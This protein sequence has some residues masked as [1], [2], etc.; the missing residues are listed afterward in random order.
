MNELEIPQGMG[1][2]IRT[3]GSKRT[4][5]EI[6]RDFD[7]LLRLWENIRDLTMKSIAPCL[8][9]EEAS[10]IK[11]AIRDMYD[12][13]IGKVYVEGEV[14]YREAKDF[15]KMLMPS[16]AKNVQPY[17]EKVP[18]FL[19]FKVEQQ[20]DEMYQ[21]VVKLKSGG[22]LVIQQT[23]ALISIDVNSGKATKER[24]IEATALKTNVEAAQEVARQCR[25]RDLAG[26]LVIDFIDMEE[27][28]NNR[29]VE[30]KL[31]DAL[32]HDRARI[33]VGRIST[34]GLMEMSRQ[35]RRSGIVDGTTGLC[36]TCKGAGAVRSH[37]MAALRILRAVEEEALKGR[38]GIISAATSPEVALF[39][40]NEKRDW[41]HRI[42]TA[43]SL[44][45]EILSDHTKAGD[46]YDI[47]KRGAAREPD[48]PLPV[49][50]ADLADIPEA[51]EDNDTPEA[52][53]DDEEKPSR[54]RRRRRRRR[55]GKNDE[56]T[57]ATDALEEKAEATDAAAEENVDAE[58]HGDDEEENPRRRR[59]RGRRGG[60]RNK[61]R[62][63]SEEGAIE[64]SS[65]SE[66]I[67][68]AAND[69]ESVNADGN[70][71]SSSDADQGDAPKRKRRPRRRTHK[72]AEGDSGEAIPT[73]AANG[74]NEEVANKAPKADA[75]PQSASQSAPVVK[76]KPA[77]TPKPKAPARKGWWQKALGR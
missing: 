74:A 54:K 25:L 18:L 29:T 12:K 61:R 75:T 32:K 71:Q 19:N 11:R 46:H 7:Y 37:E 3:A 33:Q 13:D 35:R 67:S 60:R 66:E 9:Y 21:P 76:E 2:I 49:V 22:Y 55:G 43:Y 23:E 56:E 58:S 36:P 30:K 14:G 27:N 40:L 28:R 5:T 73:T 44:K 59:R 6:K 69:T 47:E 64:A 24:N 62:D 42:E 57:V 52:G 51:A 16:H 68:Q 63:Q 10:L 50:T 45:V 41:L 72:S 38:A 8:I 48:A 1:L 77:D 26:L 70:D 53:I 4:K 15:M 17:K 34:F 65:G 20:L 31:K 39:I